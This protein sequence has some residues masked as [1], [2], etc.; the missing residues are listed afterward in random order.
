MN[1]KFRLREIL[2]S[3]GPKSC[4]KICNFHSHTT[5]S[6]GS[7]SPTELII[8]ATEKE[9]SHIAVTDHHTTD[10]FPE[11]YQWL[12]EQKDQ[13]LTPP[14]LWTGIEITCLLRKCLVHVLGLD[15]D[16]TSTSLN[17]YRNGES[18]IGQ[19]LEAKSVVR[20]IHDAGGLAILAHPARYRLN[21][22]ILIDEAY[23]NNFDGAEAW[24][25]YSYSEVWKPSPIICDS[26]NNKLRNL[27]MLST[28]G[29][30]THGYDLN[31]R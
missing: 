25:D 13:A 17:I 5:F 19:D 12:K 28:C 1:H 31:S 30:D 29:T 6:D 16:L 26:I 4:P 9:L 11:M 14:F 21:Y 7:L 27:G 10:A 8:Q 24:Y 15:I 2:S 23:I 20:A 3:I 22:N 18:A